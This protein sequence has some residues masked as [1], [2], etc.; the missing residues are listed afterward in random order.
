MDKEL[1]RLSELIAN[2]CQYARTMGFDYMRAICD[3]QLIARG[4]AICVKNSDVSDFITA[5]RSISRIG[6]EIWRFFYEQLDKDD[7]ELNLQDLFNVR[8]QQS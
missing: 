1:T 7:L 6:F 2:R 5:R 4:A 8:Q 3:C